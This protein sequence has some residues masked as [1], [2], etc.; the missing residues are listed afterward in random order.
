[1]TK[2]AF[3]MLELVMV[4]VVLGILAA[5]ALPR[6]ERD[7]RNEAAENILGAIRHT[8]HLAL[9]DNK[10]IPAAPSALNRTNWQRGLWLLRF[11]S[12]DSGNRWFYTISSSLDGDSNVDANEAALD[13]ATG[14]LFYHRAGDA[15]L[16][17]TDESPYIF[18]GENF[19]IQNVDF[20]R[21]TGQTGAGRTDNAATHVAFDYMGR[22]HKGI[23]N[24]SN[25]YASVMHQACIIE[26]TFE[27]TDIQPLQVRIEP[28][29]GY[30]FIV[31]QDNS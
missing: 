5:L 6:I 15:T 21:C 7:I 8:Q 30:A 23:F 20:S 14:K 26:F 18:L 22:P 1:M 10:N 3:T 9:M 16:D 27:D 13:P 11:S 31:G 2:K 19:G 29:T 4:I 17:E 24:A 12:Y 28:E 25:D